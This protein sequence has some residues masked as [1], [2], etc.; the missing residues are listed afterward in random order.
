MPTG[1]CILRLRGIHIQM[2]G[3]L[4][5][6]HT[7]C[8]PVIFSQVCL[9]PVGEVLFYYAELFADLNEGGDGAVKVL[10]LMSGR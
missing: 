5:M 3:Q 6:W 1:A 8:P 7:C 4:C 9:G 2:G 10:A